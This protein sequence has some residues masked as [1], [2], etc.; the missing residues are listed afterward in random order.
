MLVKCQ[1]TDYCCRGDSLAKSNV[2]DFFTNSYEIDMDSKSRRTANVVLQQTEQADDL[3]D[4]TCTPRRVGRPRH[5]RVPYLP[6]HPKAKQKQC[7][8]QAQGHNNLPNFIGRY[9]PRRDDPYEHTFYCASM[10]MLLKPWRNIE[11]DLKL[12][13]QTWES[14]FE[15]FLSTAPC[16]TRHIVSGIQYFH[17]CE[18]SAHRDSVIQSVE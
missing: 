4:L 16:K 15:M 8:F 1:V 3:S 7:I 14:A 11:T 10:L 2:I 5:E 13:T 17:E 9:F 6:T 18:S 12:P